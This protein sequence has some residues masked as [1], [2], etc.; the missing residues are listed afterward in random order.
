MSTEINEKGSEAPTFAYKRALAEIIKLKEER[1]AFA[2]QEMTNLLL[3]M[4]TR[5]I[6]CYS[7]KERGKDKEYFL[8]KKFVDD[9]ITALEKQ[10]KKP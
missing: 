9:L 8:G 7:Q 3:S 6:Q 4:Q 2:L 5:P 1:N 10:Y